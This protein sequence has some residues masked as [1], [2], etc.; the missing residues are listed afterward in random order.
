[1]R[2]FTLIIVAMLLFGTQAWADSITFQDTWMNW[3]NDPSCRT[4]LGPQYGIPN[5][6]SLTVHLKLTS[7]EV[8][9]SREFSNAFAPDAANDVI[10]GTHTPEPNPE[11][12][13]MVLLGIGLLGIAGLGR[14][15]LQK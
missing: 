13:T 14:R 5:I 8:D 15:K 7:P 9:L 2:K 6:K 12:A 3:N 10:G 4:D 11:P 1:M